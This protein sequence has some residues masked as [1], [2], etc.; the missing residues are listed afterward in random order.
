[1]TII[2][3]IAINS[4]TIYRPTKVVIVT[5]LDVN[6]SINDTLDQ[7]VIPLYESNVYTSSIKECFFSL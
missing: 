1:M 3:F 2:S 5:G 6:C 4:E 7:S